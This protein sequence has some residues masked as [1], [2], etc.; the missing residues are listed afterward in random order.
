MPKIGLSKP[1]YNILTISEDENGNTVETLGN[2][3]KVFAKAVKANT[4]I[5]TSKQKFFSDDD[6]AEIINE[7]I[8]GSISMDVDDIEDIV[9]K[10]I[11]GVHV[12]EDGT[13]ILKDT[14]SANY[15]RFGFLIRRY[16]RNKSQYRAIVFP[17][18]MFDIPADDY[19]TKGESIVFKS[20]TIT[21][22]ILRNKS[23]EWKIMSKW[24]D[25]EELAETWL[26]ENMKPPVVETEPEAGEPTE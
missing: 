18:V 19:E 26:I 7:F 21:G 14:D 15:I 1:R 9:L 3:S 23:H 8:N 25:S 5:N 10:D 16:K 11:C 2:E 20:E 22:E 24:V 6:V 13:V 4:S 12:G 17:K